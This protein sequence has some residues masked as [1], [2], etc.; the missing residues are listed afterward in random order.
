VEILECIEGCYEIQDVEF[1]KVYRW[2]PE[3]VMVECD[4]GESPTLTYSESVCVWCDADHAST[5][6]EEL[7]H[8][9]PEDCTAHPWRYAEYRE[10][11]GIPY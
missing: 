2:C 6:R 4:C 8:R 9:L 3:C 10:D 1:G 11:A 5:I 7:A